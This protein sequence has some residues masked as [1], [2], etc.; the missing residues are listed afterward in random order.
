MPLNTPP[1]NQTEW[2]GRKGQRQIMPDRRMGK[3]F[4]CANPSQQ[5][6]WIRNNIHTWGQRV[7]WG[8]I[9][10]C[11]ESATK[12]DKWPASVSTLLPTCIDLSKCVTLRIHIGQIL[13]TLIAGTRGG[14]LLEWF[15]NE[16]PWGRGPPWK[17]T[18]IFGGNW[19]CFSGESSSFRLF[20][21]KSPKEETPP[22]ERSFLRSTCLCANKKCRRVKTHQTNVTKISQTRSLMRYDILN[23]FLR[24][25]YWSL[26]GF[27]GRPDTTLIYVF[28]VPVHCSHKTSLRE[29]V[30]PCSCSLKSLGNT[31][32]WCT[33][34]DSA[35]VYFI[36]HKVNLDT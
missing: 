23:L 2:G 25:N 33:K 7:G 22:G 26:R 15:L 14:F 12:M 28:P 27:A 31:H 1:P 20:M 9:Q 17:T 8:L 21:V 19:D 29:Q 13:D 30:V 4:S 24:N 32:C 3:F 10:N 16:K 5:T 18:P 36:S 6:V 34:V 35:T 11:F